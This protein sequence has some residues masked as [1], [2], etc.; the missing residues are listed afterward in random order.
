MLISSEEGSGDIEAHHLHRVSMIW[1]TKNK[2]K[3]RSL[4]EYLLHAARG[5][6]L[7]VI[8]AVSGAI[9]AD[10]SAYL[11]K[12]LTLLNGAGVCRRWQGSCRCHTANRSR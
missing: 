5:L 2:P 1:R 8:D 11:G 9:R 10:I 3:K 12:I 4:K 7:E 6:K